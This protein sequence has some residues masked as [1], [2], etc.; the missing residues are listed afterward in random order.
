[1]SF[2]IEI[3]A[4]L[5]RRRGHSHRRA[6][7]TDRKT[8]PVALRPCLPTAAAFAEFI[9]EKLRESNQTGESTNMVHAKDAMHHSENCCRF[10]IGVIQKWQKVR[11]VQ[12]RPKTCISRLVMRPE[13]ACFLH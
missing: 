8:A 11:P 3:G 7:A 9:T 13:L 2:Q 5:G 6:Q 1:M 4:G 10:G 12:V